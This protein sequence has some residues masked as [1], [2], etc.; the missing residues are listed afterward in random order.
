MSDSTIISAGTVRQVWRYPV[1]S[2]QGETLAEAQVVEGGIVGDRAYALIDQSNG[3]IASAKFPRKWKEL[4]DF[5]ATYLG[6][7]EDGSA[8]PPVRIT[9]PDGTEAT[10]E[11]ADVSARLSARL[12]RE[13]SLTATRPE[14]MSLERLDPFATDET[15]LDIGPI[16]MKGRFSDYAALH[17]V[18]TA[19]L[20]RLAELY[21]EGQFEALR[22]RPN[23]LIESP[24]GEEGFMENEWVGRTIAIGDEVRLKVTDP[25]PRCALPALAQG[26]LRNEPQVLRTIN[27]HNRLPVPAL[28]GQ[29]LPCAGIYAFVTRGGKIRPGDV[30]RVE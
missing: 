11:E 24:A 26:G 3:K 28:G 19:T 27:A 30:V 18:T 9:W 10:S 15:I 20:A 23:V 8:L 12:S 22:F 2:M 7:P 16:M 5:S 25:T 1:K 6:A 17:L 13:V 21:P 14:T 29:E 4:L